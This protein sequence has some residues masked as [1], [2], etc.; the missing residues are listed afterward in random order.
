[1]SSKTGIGRCGNTHNLVSICMTQILRAEVWL[2][3]KMKLKLHHSC[4]TS[5]YQD[6]LGKEL[7][8]SVT[9]KIVK[10]WFKTVK[11]C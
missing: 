2:Y 4:S 6:V 5:E 10:G 7:K 3:T 8:I 11:I 1:M 9:E